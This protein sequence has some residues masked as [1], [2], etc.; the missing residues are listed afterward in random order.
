MQKSVSNGFDSQDKIH[1]QRKRGVH[2]KQRI[3]NYKKL[4]SSWYI[5]INSRIEEHERD[6]RDK[7]FLW[8]IRMSEQWE[9]WKSANNRSH[10]HSVGINWEKVWRK[11]SLWGRTS[12]WT[13]QNCIPEVCLSLRTHSQK[14]YRNVYWSTQNGTLFPWKNQWVKK[15]GCCS[16]IHKIIF[17]SSQCLF[18]IQWPKSSTRYQS[19]LP[20]RCKSKSYVT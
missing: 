4:I 13:S 3:E 14:L 12:W 8:S 20:F 9:N 1:C 6:Q 17:D 5:K 15:V 10:E 19:L 2:F 16:S 11:W 18:A 7:L